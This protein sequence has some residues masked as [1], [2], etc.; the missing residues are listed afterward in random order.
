MKLFFFFYTFLDITQHPANDTYCEGTNAVLSCVIFDTSPDDVADSSGWF[1]NT[2]P[3][4][5]L[6]SNMISNSR[7]ADVVTSVLTIESVSLNDNGDGYSCYPTLNIR[8]YSG[9]ISVAG[10]YTHTCVHDYFVK[11]NRT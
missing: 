10:E 4:G 3:P 7:D 11:S 5:A 2:D 6:L 8:S 9:V 1:I